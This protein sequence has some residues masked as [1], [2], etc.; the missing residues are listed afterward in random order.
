MQSPVDFISC[1]QKSVM[2]ATDAATSLAALPRIFDRELKII[3]NGRELGWSW[4]EQ[5]VGELHVRLREIKIDV[6]HAARDGNVLLERHIVTAVDRGSGLPWQAEIMAVYE[7]TEDDKIR[8][9]R[10]LAQIPGEYT[11]W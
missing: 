5:H 9:W 3:L 7:L 8:T 2:E 10:E 1:L 4:L 6:T 11:G